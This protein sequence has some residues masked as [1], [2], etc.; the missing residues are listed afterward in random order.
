M[1][2]KDFALLFYYFPAYNYC[3]I[4]IQNAVFINTTSPASSEISVPDA[5]TN[6]ISAC[7]IAAASFIPSPVN[8]VIPI[9]LILSTIITFV[10]GKTSE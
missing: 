5:I 3:F 2:K 10:S 4:N 9:F 8:P 6:P 1:P 7:A